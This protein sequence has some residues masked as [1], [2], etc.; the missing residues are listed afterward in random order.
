MDQQTAIN[1]LVQGAH[2][3]QERGL[4]K[5]QDASAVIQAIQVVQPQPEEAPLQKVED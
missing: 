3:A 1:V 2:L 5:L 4:L